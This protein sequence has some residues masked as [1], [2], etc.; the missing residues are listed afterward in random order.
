MGLASGRRDGGGGTMVSLTR[1]TAVALAALVTACSL[2]NATSSHMG[3]S[4]VD[5]GPQEDAYASP[6]AG[7]VGP[8][9]IRVVNLARDNAS[10]DVLLRDGASDV[11]LATALTFTSATRDRVEVPAGA[12]MVD[13]LAGGSS[14]FSEMVGPFEANVDY[15][16]AFLGDASEPPFA[17][18][19][20]G[21]LV[22]EDD[23]SGLD[24]R[25]DIRLSVVHLASPVSEG[26][27]VT[28]DRTTGG[29][30][31]LAR[32]VDF[33][34]IVTI[35]ALRAMSYRVG[36][37]AGGEGTLDVRFDLPDYIPGTYANVFI[38]A[39]PDDSVFLLSVTNEGGTRTLEVLP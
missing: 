38:G 3:G 5:A 14:V 36:F 34:G 28:I 8:P 6:D 18:R 24:E 27:L 9:R 21:L 30:E 12:W 22:L 1:I 25:N 7:R 39:R 26:S 16:L 17:G 37:D 15:T 10:V 29:F 32:G 31:V 33:R 23:A 35:D 11:P 2:V 20:L 13:V 4:S 19:G